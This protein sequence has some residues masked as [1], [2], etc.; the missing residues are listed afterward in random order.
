M[1]FTNLL[2]TR[3]EELRHQIDHHINDSDSDFVDMDS[4]IAAVSKDPIP[5]KELLKMRNFITQIEGYIELFAD[6]SVTMQMTRNKLKL[7]AEKFKRD[8]NITDEEELQEEKKE[9]LIRDGLYQ[10]LQNLKKD[11]TDQQSMLDAVDR[12]LAFP[13]LKMPV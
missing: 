1:P 9:V 10:S 8:N 7:A 6:Y 13:S 4:E 2:S 5:I 11:T 3:K 12:V